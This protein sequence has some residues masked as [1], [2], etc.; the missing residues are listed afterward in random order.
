MNSD[1][2]NIFTDHFALAGMK[3]STDVYAEQLDLIRNGASA[4]DATRRAVESCEKT[5]AGRFHLAATE[6]GKHAPD[7]S[8]MVVEQITP[9]LVAEACSLLRRPPATSTTWSS[10][11]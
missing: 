10:V 2:A 9:A 6:T 11:R 3:S 1:A 5:I 4:A 8:M 7:R